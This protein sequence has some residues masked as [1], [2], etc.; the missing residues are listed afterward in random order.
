MSLNEKPC[1]LCWLCLNSTLIFF[2]GAWRIKSSIVSTTSL[3][4]K[5][6]LVISIITEEFGGTFSSLFFIMG[7]LRKDTSFRNLNKYLFSSCTTNTAVLKLLLMMKNKPT[8]IP[9]I[10]PFKRSVVKI[11][12]MVIT[13]GKN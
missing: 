10:T 12:I 2:N 11:A 3:S 8:P 4:I 7:L 1:F 6:A 9:I 5:S 13:N